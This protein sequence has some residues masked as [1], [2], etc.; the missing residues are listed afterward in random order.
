MNYSSQQKVYEE[1]VD[2]LGDSEDTPTP[3]HLFNH[4]KYLEQCIKETNRMYSPAIATIR[5]MHKE[6]VLKGTFCIRIQQLSLA[7]VWNKFIIQSRC[8]FPDNKI[9]PINTLVFLAI[10][11]AQYDKELYANPLKWDPEHFNELAVQ[12][13][14]K[15]SQLSFGYGSRSCLGKIQTT[16]LHFSTILIQYLTLH[17]GY[18]YAMMSIKSQIAHILRNYHLSTDIT[19]FTRKDLLMDVTIRSKIG[20]PIKLTTRQWWHWWKN[21]SKIM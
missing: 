20:F 1:I 19:E 4:F 13:R 10:H 21:S 11:W 3:D 6:C 8:F 5:R 7:I 15:N 16:N 9:V 18:R 14:P 17:T 2:L 12:S